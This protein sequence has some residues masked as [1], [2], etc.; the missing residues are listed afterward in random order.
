MKYG[1]AGN[2]HFMVLEL[3]A[4]LMQEFLKMKGTCLAG[5]VGENDIG[6]FD[7]GHKGQVFHRHIGAQVN[8][9]QAPAPE[10]V[11]HK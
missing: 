4:C 5:Q 6:L 2:D 11:M 7:P 10:Q 1:W 3:Y 8:Y 9:F